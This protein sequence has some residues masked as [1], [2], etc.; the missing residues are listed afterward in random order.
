MKKK[1]IPAGFIRRMNNQLGDEFED[2]LKAL[3]S[4]PVLSLRINPLKDKGQ[5]AANEKIPWCGSGRY[6]DQR[7]EF[8]FDPFIHAGGYYVQEASSMLFT[9]AIDFQRDKR[10]LD[11]CASPGGKSSLVLSNLAQDGIL[12]S[13]EL[14]RKRAAI[15]YENLVKW[16][17]GNS[18]VT[19][20]RV[21]DYNDFEGYFDVVLVDAPCSGEGMFRK[22]A[23]AI[24]EW[25]ESRP[26]K[27]SIEQ[28]NILDKAI[29]LVRPGGKLIYSTCTF[30]KEENEQIVQWFYAKFSP[31]LEPG[32]MPLNPDWKVRKEE[33]QHTDGT[34]HEIYKCLPHLF[35]GE[36]LFVAVFQKKNGQQR[37][38]RKKQHFQAVLKK[39][40]STEKELALQFCELP[41]FW[42]LRKKDNH[43]LLLPEK[44]EPEVN[45]AYNKLN[46]LK[47]GVKVGTLNLKSGELIPSHELAVSPFLSKQVISYEL[48]REDAIRYLQ[49]ENPRFETKETGWAVVSFMGLTLGWIKILPGRINNFYPKEWKIR[50]QGLGG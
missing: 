31:L 2:L 42:C 35:R 43:I 29:H 16:G 45:R 26:F 12:F 46:V 17:Y 23:T 20:A 30:S 14:V 36:G 32:S 6:L 7:P 47:A 22:S 27:C 37:A 5:F 49:K 48:A 39:L 9:Q 38:G 50:K 41:E 3:E 19:T 24:S 44:Y 13:N 28:K 21:A 11:L 10:I 25:N 33:I 18:I 15:L 4:E 8:V 40:S 34:K 1:S